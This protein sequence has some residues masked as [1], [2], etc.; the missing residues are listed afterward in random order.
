MATAIHSQEAYRPTDVGTTF[1]GN[2]IQIE[3]TMAGRWMA[4]PS[5]TL[6]FA[7]AAAASTTAVIFLWISYQDDGKKKSSS[8]SSTQKQSYESFRQLSLRHAKIRTKQGTIVN[9]TNTE[10]LLSLLPSHLKREHSKESRRRQMIPRLIMKKKMYDNIVMY[11]PSGAV[12]CTVGEKKAKWYVR[13]GLAIWKTNLPSDDGERSIQLTFEPNT[14]SR[15][16]K[17]NIDPEQVHDV[18]PEDDDNN[19]STGSLYNQSLKRNQCVVCGSTQNYM[20]HYIVPFCYRTRL[21]PQYKTHLPHDVVLLC[22]DTCQ[23]EAFR[24]RMKRQKELEQQQYNWNQDAAKGNEID[25]DN[26]DT[27]H[28][29]F[30]DPDLQ[31]VRSASLALL[32]WGTQL[33][34][35]R[36]EDCTRVVAEY[37]KIDPSSVTEA[38]LQKGASLSFRRVNPKFISGPERVVWALRDDP[39]LIARFVKMWRQYFLDTMRPKYLPTGWNVNS[40]VQCDR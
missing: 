27:V 33:P 5:S 39:I 3:T 38:V 35:E 34:S 30:I 29:Y 24:S 20:R 13:K 37:F 16:M 4:S 9:N 36:A 17:R 25:N 7:C 18:Y 14:T 31:Q 32:R 6:V 1:D 40:P 11:D 26:D 23:V 28:P 19:Y 12:L 10:H 15:K 2:W 21:P 8:S 22:A